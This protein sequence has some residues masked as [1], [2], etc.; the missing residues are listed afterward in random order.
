VIEFLE[1]CGFASDQAK[2]ALPRVEKAFGRLG[3]GAQEIEQAKNRLCTYYDLDLQ[4][5]RKL[6]GLFVKSVV[7]TV[8]LREEGKVKVVHAC[9]APGMEVIGSA[10]MTVRRDVALMNPNFAFMVVLGCIFGRYV[11]VLEA[12]ERLW[13]RSGG[14]T[15]CGMVKSRLGLLSLNM[16]PRP[17]V[18]VTS[19]FTCD[20]SP[21]T[22]ELIEYFEGIPACFVDTCQD[23]QLFEYP[24]AIRATRLAAKSMRA[25]VKRLEQLLDI[26][27]TDDLVFQAVEARR[28]L[29]EI[30]DKIGNLVATNSPVPLG[31]THLNL[32]YGVGSIPYTAEQLPEAV[33]AV[34][35][36]HDELR[37]RVSRGEGAVPNGTPRLLSIQPC[38]HTDP[39]LEWLVDQMGMVVVAWDFLG[40]SEVGRGG[41]GVVDPSD[42]YELLCQRLHGSSSQPLW[43]RVRI[44]LDM[45]RRYRLDGVLN[46][47]HAGCRYLAGDAFFIQEAIKRELGIPVLT[48]EWENFDPRTHNEQEHRA[49][50]EAFRLLLGKGR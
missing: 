39:Q 31:S 3:L 9:M 50:L 30:C 25:A 17:D 6:L 11:P 4:G 44:I 12:A 47:F 18:T 46:H 28:P 36:L 48:F 40:T 1:M 26:E 37:G 35:T 10:I 34:Q 14:M 23:R 29:D 43:G 33:E 13:L 27:I 15:H 7:D 42:P 32:F 49:R 22:N 2:A 16:I 5:I 19:G 21:K 38:H 20:T 45:C 24:E 41:L 8:L